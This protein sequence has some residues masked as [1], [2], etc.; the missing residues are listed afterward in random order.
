MSPA[1][2]REAEQRILLLFLE[3]EEYQMSSGF[4]EVLDG[5]KR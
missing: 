4:L 1:D 5:L 2:F 3:K